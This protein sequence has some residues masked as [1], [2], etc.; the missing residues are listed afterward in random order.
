MERLVPPVG[1]RG[2]YELKTPWSTQPGVVYTC[3]ALRKFVDLTNQGID[4][5]ETYY[6]P[7]GLEVGDYEQDRRNNELIVT[8][9]SDTEAPIYVPTSYILSYPNQGYRNYQHVVL[10]AS[11]GPLP[12]YI[13][14]SFAKDQVSSVLSDT[15]GMSPEVHL[16]VAPSDGVVSAE[17][18]DVLEAARVAAITNRTTDYARVLEL[19]QQNQTLME[20]ITLLEQLV[21]DNGLLP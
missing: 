1:T 10:S 17:D 6:G 4:I 11:L 13:D 18:H 19:Q 16:S 7:A 5:Y 8:L 2:L 21:I 3:A 14:L 9:I 20:R 15:L 12:D